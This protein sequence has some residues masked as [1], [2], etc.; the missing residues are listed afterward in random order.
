M[1]E[2]NKTYKVLNLAKQLELKLRDIY[3]LHSHTFSQDSAFWWKLAVEEGNHASLLDTSIQFLERGDLI[4][5]LFDIGYA[6][7]ENCVQRLNKL[8]EEYKVNH[9]TRYQA[10]RTAHRLEQSVGET[11]YQKI[12]E[13]PIDLIQNPQNIIGIFQKLNNA[14]KNHAERIFSY[15]MEHNITT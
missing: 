5:P 14:D 3:L 11:H 9:P 4:E 2:I 10:F 1:A 8:H 7:L 6:T 13:E 12:M 15:M